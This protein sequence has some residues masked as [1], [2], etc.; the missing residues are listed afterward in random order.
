[1]TGRQLV[2]AALWANGVTAKQTAEI[3]G[4]TLHT[5][6]SARVRLQRKYAAAGIRV[7]NGVDMARILAAELPR[8]TPQRS[9][10]ARLPEP[11]RSGG[12][13]STITPDRLAIVQQ[14][15]ADGLSFG[16][17]ADQLGVGRNAVS[18]AFARAERDAAVGAEE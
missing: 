14:L 17:I 10:T 8:I 12:R 9:A 5:A 7:R 6:R 18:R 15:R 16:R 11:G 2:Y 13:P 4:V 1:M 3:M